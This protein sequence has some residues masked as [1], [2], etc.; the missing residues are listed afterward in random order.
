[1]TIAKKSLSLF[2]SVIM[3]FSIM[4]GLDFSAYALEESGIC[5]ENATYTFD[6]ATGTVTVSGSGPMYDWGSLDSNI[7]EEEELSLFSSRAV[8]SASPFTNNSSITQLVVEDGVTTVGKNAFR[9]CENLTRVELSTSITDICEYAF[10]NCSALT[11]VFYTGSENQWNSVVV[12][13][14]NIPLSNANVHFGYTRPCYHTFDLGVCTL[15]GGKQIGENV[16]YILDTETGVLTISGKGYMYDWAS[17]DSNLGEEEELFSLRQTRVT[18]NFASPFV[19][20]KS[21]KTVI[22]EPE[23]TN[24]GKNAFRGNE[25]ITE[26][27][28]YDT[29]D[30]IGEYAFYNCNGLTDVYYTK[31]ESDWNNIQIEAN[32]NSLNFATIHYNYSPRCEHNFVLS[33]SDINDNG[34]IKDKFICSICQEEKYK[35]VSDKS[36]LSASVTTLS[37]MVNA[38]DAS[39]RYNA[40]AIESAKSVLSNAQGYLDSRYAPQSEVD[41]CADV[42][43]TE[44]SNL[45]SIGLAQFTLNFIVYDDENNEEITSSSSTVSYGELVDYS[46]DIPTENGQPQYF[47]YKWTKNVNG[48]DVLVRNLSNE[49]SVVAKENVTYTCHVLK[50]D[51]ATEQKTTTRVYFVDKSGKV[52]L[53]TSAQIGVA[54]DETSVDVKAP[55]VPFYDFVGWIVESGNK[56]TVSET[57]LVLRAKYEFAPVESNKCTIKGLNNALI[58]DKSE[59]DA[60]YD[61]KVILSGGKYYAFCDENGNIISYINMNYFYAPHKSNGEIVYITAIEEKSEEGSITISGYF[62]KENAGTVVSNGQTIS[63]NRL[64]VTSQYYLPTNAIPVEAGIIASRSATTAD[65][66]QIGKAN[67]SKLVSDSQGKNGEFTTYMG[68]VNPNYAYVRSY[69]IYKNTDGTTKTVYSDVVRIYY[70][71]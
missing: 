3:L 34:E 33:E 20:N 24:I 27:Y 1:M 53:V 47:V 36:A 68:F 17:Q 45:N 43:N 38:D 71:V 15:C 5:G 4:V 56:D 37:T 49:I 59:Y 28:I 11:D 26:V 42:V 50:N 41:Y 22:I 12:S 60:Y 32:N 16:A 25:N 2:L 57:E 19:S 63:V 55:A 23:V 69:L 64:Y 61:E 44:I 54:F 29:V 52:L 66:L 51:P 65:T 67:V 21:I 18:K 14:N 8:N 39:Y 58:N 40:S 30:L 31:S 70:S 7:G 35:I 13:N 10:Y 6:S 9:G 48:T 46:F 62:T